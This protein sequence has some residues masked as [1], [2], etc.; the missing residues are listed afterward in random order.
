[1]TQQ[2]IGAKKVMIMPITVGQVAEQKQTH[3]LS[4][5]NKTLPAFLGGYTM[6]K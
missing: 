5:P 1:M 2:N 6:T 3:G 4:K